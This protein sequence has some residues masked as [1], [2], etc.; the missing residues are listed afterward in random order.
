[1]L[2]AV[3]DNGHGAHL[4]ALPFEVGYG[5]A[6][7]VGS[8]HVLPETGDGPEDIAEG[9][10]EVVAHGGDGDGESGG[11]GVVPVHAG[12]GEHAVEVFLRELA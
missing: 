5:G 2:E 4:C 12:P 11:G 8:D 7:I 6:E 1:M 9:E 3:V 10:T